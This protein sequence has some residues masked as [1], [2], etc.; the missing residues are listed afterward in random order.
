MRIISISNDHNFVSQITAFCETYEI[1][2]MPAANDVTA[3]NHL[4]FFQPD[5]VICDYTSLSYMNFEVFL[6]MFRPFNATFQQL[7]VALPSPDFELSTHGDFYLMD[8]SAEIFEQL[9]WI[10]KCK[11]KPHIHTVSITPSPENIHFF[12]SNQKANRKHLDADYSVQIFQCIQSIK[13]NLLA[14]KADDLISSLDALFAILNQSKNYQYCAH[15][16]F[17]LNEFLDT[18]YAEHCQTEPPK[19]LSI[20]MFQIISEAMR[21]YKSQFLELSNLLADQNLAVSTPIYNIMSY[22]SEHYAEDLSLDFIS[23]IFHFNPSYLSSKFRKETNLKLIDYIN[24]VRI[25]LAARLL[26]LTNMKVNVISETVGY[27]NSKYFF[28]IFKKY[29]KMPPSEYRKQFFSSSYLDSEQ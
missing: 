26:E 20:N 8:K 18:I 15:I 25:N 5:Y 9:L 21:Y 3:L 13:L 1:I 4:L 17:H 10:T 27:S 22:I 28:R 2:Y 29:F 14:A 11:D 12:R 6:D 7:I 16:L 19:H 23:V 24:H